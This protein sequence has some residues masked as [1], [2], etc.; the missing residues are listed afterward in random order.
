MWSTREGWKVQNELANT[1][2]HTATTRK[3]I[4]TLQ[5]KRLQAHCHKCW[6]GWVADALRYLQTQIKYLLKFEGRSEPKMKHK[7]KGWEGINDD[8]YID[9]VL[10]ARLLENPH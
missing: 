5:Q 7:S 2:K 4:S 1:C 6:W 9:E 10:Q 8:N 3:V